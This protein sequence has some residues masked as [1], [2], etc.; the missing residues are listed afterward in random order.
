MHDRNVPIS[1]SPYPERFAQLPGRFAQLLAPCWL[2]GLVT[3]IVSLWLTSTVRGDVFHLANGAEVRGQWVNREERSPARMVIQTSAGIRLTL[4]PSQ[5]ARTDREQP[6][7][8]Q[9]EQLAPQ[10][11]DTVADQWRL[12]EWCRERN[13]AEHRARHLR[14][15]V[16]LDPQHEAAWH[17]LGYSQLGGEWILRKEFLQEQGYVYFQGRWRLSQE[18]DVI[19][20]RQKIELAAK[21]WLARLKTWRT[22]IDKGQA[23][24]AVRNIRAVRDPAAIT[25]LA[26]LLAR[27]PLR[28]IRL[29]YVEVLGRIDDP[30]ATDV[31][32]ATCL[33]NPDIE[34][35]HAALEEVVPR[36]SPA[37]VKV[38]VNTLRDSDNQRVNRAAH[39]LGKLN[40]PTTI[41]PLIDALVTQHVVQNPSL[42]GKPAGATTAGIAYGSRDEVGTPIAQFNVPKHIRVGVPN[43]E[44]LAALVEIGGGVS[45]GFDQRAWR[46]WHSVFQKEQSTR[47]NARRD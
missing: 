47:L 29:L 28:P 33:N 46:D 7:I 15:I 26:Y 20:S 16:E 43:H 22:Q 35:F 27:E 40:D 11:R 1:I 23:D 3:T 34:V 31:L 12:A 41:V 44:A 30:R 36:T 6:A 39:A 21:E 2:A 4:L 38:F 25:A 17:G 42:A 37:V 8:D 32:V 13:L 45:F 19:Q 18:I 5:I 14:R 24:S 9:Y 10:F